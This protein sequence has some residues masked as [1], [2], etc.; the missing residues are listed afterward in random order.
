MKFNARAADLRNA[1]QIVNM[2]LKS[3]TTNPILD[4]VLLEADQDALTLTGTDTMMQVSFAVP[5]EVEVPGK[6][7]LRGKLLADVVSRMED[8]EMR[9]DVD[10]KHVCTVKCG[11]AKS[12]LAGSDPET[13]PVK[14]KVDAVSK[15]TIPATEFYNMIS[16]IE[17]CIALDDMRQVLTGGCIDVTSGIIS[18]VGLDGFRLAV[19]ELRP[20]SCPDDC[21]VIIPGKSLAVIKK[22][23]SSAGDEL[24][25]LNFSDKEFEMQ[26][27][28]ANIKCTL[29]EGDYVNWRG[30]VPQSFKTLCTVDAEQFS[31]AVERA[32]LMARLG[33]NNLI[34]L[35]IG[36]D[37][38]TV[39]ATSGIDEMQE[40]VDAEVNGEPMNIAFNVVYLSDA[41]KMFDTGTIVLHFNSSI[42]PCVVCPTTAVSEFFWLILPVRTSA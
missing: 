1:L 8:S 41:M 22:L 3:K 15:I 9:F 32:A 4:C 7:A 24:I 42:Q 2:A 19:K 12:R 16:G 33:S 10:D 5:C 11:R 6:T 31:G 39:Y 20:S 14:P 23:L 17:K 27:A 35:S 25:D 29:I 40:I 26:F 13:F 30:I 36:E 34:K 37:S 38:I 28:S 21:K 18:M